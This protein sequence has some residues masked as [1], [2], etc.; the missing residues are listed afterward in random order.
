MQCR[1]RHAA[2]P[3]RLLGVRSTT[4]ISWFAFPLDQPGVTIRP[5]REMTGDAVFN[6][7]FLDDAVVRR[8]GPHRRRGQRLGGH[9]DDAASSSAPASARAVRTRA[10]PCPGPKGGMLGRRAGDA[11]ADPTPGG[12]PGAEPR[13]T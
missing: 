11:A 10:S 9:A 13:R 8:R 7:V 4:G 3:H 5:L 12:E 2:R 6:E 1:L